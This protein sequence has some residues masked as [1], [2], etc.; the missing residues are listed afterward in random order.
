MV[1]NQH[2]CLLES[3]LSK[4]GIVN[5]LYHQYQSVG[6]ILFAGAYFIFPVRTIETLNFQGA[7]KSLDF[8]QGIRIYRNTAVGS[9]A[10]LNQKITI[11]SLNNHFESYVWIKLALE[12]IKKIPST[13]YFSIFFKKIKKY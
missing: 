6:Q 13:G 3:R 7:K 9:A 5:F 12:S 2:L 11:N 1:N 10:F 8:I 4:I